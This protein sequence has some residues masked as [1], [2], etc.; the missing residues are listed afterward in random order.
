M[1]NRW[2]GIHQ[3]CTFV[4]F[5]SPEIGDPDVSM[6]VEL[7]QKATRSGPLSSIRLAKQIGRLK[8]NSQR[9]KKPFG[10]EAL[11][12]NRVGVECR[13]WVTTCRLISIKT[14]QPTKG[15]LGDSST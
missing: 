12:N 5:R 6:P 9:T 14:L 8:T 10:A 4:T 1:N 11:G 3:R 13:S 7:T 2:G 15:L